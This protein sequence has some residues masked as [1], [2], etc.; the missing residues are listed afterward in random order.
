MRPANSL[1]KWAV[2]RKFP[3]HAKVAEYS[4]T[5]KQPCNLRITVHSLKYIITSGPLLLLQVLTVQ[6]YCE[7]CELLYFSQNSNSLNDVIT[8]TAL[9]LFLDDTLHCENVKHKS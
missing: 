1:T 6:N 4:C 9:A 2:F 5:E 8:A 3:I 7:Y